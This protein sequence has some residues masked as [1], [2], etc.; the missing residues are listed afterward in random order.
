MSFSNVGI[1]G[2]GGNTNYTDKYNFDNTARV[3]N[4]VTKKFDYTPITYYVT[5]KSSAIIR[6]LQNG[7]AQLYAVIMVAGIALA[8][9]WLIK[10]M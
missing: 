4:Q 1:F 9:L 3:Y 6:K 7:V 2:G 10:V 5:E 8:L